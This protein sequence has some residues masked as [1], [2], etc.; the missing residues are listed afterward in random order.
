MLNLIENESL[1]LIRRRRFLIV[2]AILFVIMT[3]VSYSQQRM[4]KQSRNAN[5]RADLQERIARYENRLRRGQMN[6][7]WSR[8]MRAEMRRSSGPRRT[9]PGI[10][11]PP[12]MAAAATAVPWPSPRSSKSG[13]MWTATAIVANV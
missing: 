3:L 8:S 9:R 1:K 13:I 12:T 6:E 2:V 5:W 11:I 4:M 7:S 10:C